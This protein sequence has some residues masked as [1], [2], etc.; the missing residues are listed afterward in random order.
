MAIGRSVRAGSAHTAVKR[1]NHFLAQ[2]R[3]TRVT[4]LRGMRP[5]LTHAWHHSYT[6]RTESVLGIPIPTYAKLIRRRKPVN[7][8]SAIDCGK[9]RVRTASGRFGLG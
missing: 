7:H 5:K 1:M 8:L 6:H 3:L 4:S 2:F 9:V